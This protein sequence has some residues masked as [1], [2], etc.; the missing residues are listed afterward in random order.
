MLL[1]DEEE[2]PNH[3]HARWP[4]SASFYYSLR[5][6]RFNHREQVRPPYDPVTLGKKPLPRGHRCLPSN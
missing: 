2:L 6:V 5:I 1:Q 4:G 3:C